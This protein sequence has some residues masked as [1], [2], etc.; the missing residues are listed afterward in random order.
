MG[1]AIEQ[2]IKERHLKPKLDEAR[3]KERWAELMGKPIAKYTTDVS[4][5]NG[6]LYIRIESAPLKKELT[7]SKEKIK[8]LFNKEMGEDT[9]K[10]VL[11]F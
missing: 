2:F 3:I 10:D 11:I 5:K 1:E 8:E 6:R 7:Y 4:L 9:I